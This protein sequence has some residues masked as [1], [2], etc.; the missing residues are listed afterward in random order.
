ML[1]QRERDPQ[2]AIA[3]YTWTDQTVEPSLVTG[4]TRSLFKAS[5][6][7]QDDV[8]TV[9]TLLAHRFRSKTS[10][11]QHSTHES[12]VN[13]LESG[14]TILPELIPVPVVSFNV[15]DETFADELLSVVKHL[16]QHSRRRSEQALS[17]FPVEQER[18]NSKFRNIYEKVKFHR[19][20]CC[21]QACAYN[22]W[23]LEA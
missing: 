11:S 17:V 5:S 15:I 4:E 9:Q 8:G 6:F 19:Q 12:N 22:Q 20:S 18:R 21:I 13:Q 1:N 16:V 7:I 2:G 3:P 10:P 23:M 14:R